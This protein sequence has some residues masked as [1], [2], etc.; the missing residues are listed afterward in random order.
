MGNYSFFHGHAGAFVPLKRGGERR[1][2]WISS[3]AAWSLF[4][5]IVI[6]SLKTVLMQVKAA[7]RLKHL[8]ELL[9]WSH[10]IHAIQRTYSTQGPEAGLF[11]QLRLKRCKTGWMVHWSK[12]KFLLTWVHKW[13]RWNGPYW[14]FIKR[15]GESFYVG[16]AHSQQRFCRLVISAA[17]EP[18][19][20][21]R[22][23]ALTVCYPPPSLKRSPWFR[24]HRTSL[25]VVN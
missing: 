12:S 11:C 20:T 22:R 10:A 23:A 14:P 18:G 1:R 3:V 4:C 17:T 2:G 15:E 16:D 24:F 5:I 8:L 19:H 9:C 21:L 6:M 7:I 13:H 25:A